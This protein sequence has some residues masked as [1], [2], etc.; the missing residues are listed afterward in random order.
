MAIAT[1]TPRVDSS[2]KRPC[3][4]LFMGDPAGIGPELV[5]RLLADGSAAQKADIL[6]I[7]SRP[8]LEAIAAYQVGAESGLLS[9]GVLPVA[10]TFQGHHKERSESNN[11]VS[12]HNDLETPWPTPQLPMDE[13]GH[14]FNSTLPTPFVAHQKVAVLCEADHASMADMRGGITLLQSLGKIFSTTIRE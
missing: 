8:E 13:R 12:C 2:S 7:G 1:N 9:K 11:H 3:I 14:P 5:L 10:V 4:A 6:L